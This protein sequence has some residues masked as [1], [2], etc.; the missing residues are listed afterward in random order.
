MEEDF[1]NVCDSIDDVYSKIDG[2][3]EIGSKLKERLRKGFE[4]PPLEDFQKLMG[5]SLSL[6]EAQRLLFDPAHYHIGLYSAALWSAA[7]ESFIKV[8]QGA[9]KT[10]ALLL[11]LVYLHHRY[12]S[13]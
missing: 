12:E 8:D 10:H 5:K 11:A 9:Q 2:S 1:K 7:T 4:S 6:E 13:Y 3:E